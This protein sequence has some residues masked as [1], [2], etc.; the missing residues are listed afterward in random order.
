MKLVLLWMDS[1]KELNSEDIEDFHPFPTSNHAPSN[2][3]WLRRY[4]L[5]KL[6]NAAGILH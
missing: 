1:N 6:T 3:Q 4:A 2:D 5:E